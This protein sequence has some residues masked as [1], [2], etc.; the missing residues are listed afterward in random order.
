MLTVN[1]RQAE[2]SDP[3]EFCQVNTKPLTTKLIKNLR[4]YV[5]PTPLASNFPYPQ[6]INNCH[7]NI[8]P[9]TIHFIFHQNPLLI[10]YHRVVGPQMQSL[11]C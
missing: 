9:L 1:L 5:N 3:S 8:T 10:L 6:E 7:V 4:C 2:L 11:P